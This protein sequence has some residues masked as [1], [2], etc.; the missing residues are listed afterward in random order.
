M[1]KLNGNISLALGSAVS[2]KAYLGNTLVYDKTAPIVLEPEMQATLDRIALNG[3]NAYPELQKAAVNNWLKRTKLNGNVFNSRTHIYL[4]GLGTTT[5]SLMQASKINIKNPN[6]NLAIVSGGVTLTPNGYL[7]NGV[8]GYCDN[9]FNPVAEGIAVGNIGEFYDIMD[10]FTVSAIVAFGASAFIGGNISTVFYPNINSFGTVTNRKMN[11]ND[12]V[13]G[14]ELQT[15]NG[16][17]SCYMGRVGNTRVFQINSDI[18]TSITPPASTVLN[19]KLYSGG[20]NRNNTP[21][22]FCNGTERIAMFGGAMT[23]SEVNQQ[24]IINNQYYA[25]LGLPINS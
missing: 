15:S 1:L 4:R 2:K 22:Q 19:L 20:V 7:Y 11:I 5:D 3:W 6:G 8:N 18:A 13:A 24:R 23:E 21:Q 16:N 10:D 17:K 25:E 14:L 9:Q 12:S